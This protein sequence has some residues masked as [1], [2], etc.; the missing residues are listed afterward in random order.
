MASIQLTHLQDL[1]DKYQR[2]GKKNDLE[3]L[4]EYT[5]K[6]IASLDKDDPTRPK[7]I[8]ALATWTGQRY[9]IDGNI[10]HIN[11]SID[12]IREVL[13]SAVLDDIYRAE[14]QG[15]LAL[16]LVD[17]FDI[18]KYPS[19][20]EDAISFTRGTLQVVPEDDPDRDSWLGNLGKQL[21][22][23]YHCTSDVSVLEESI[24]FSR[25]SVDAASHNPPNKAL[26]LSNLGNRL[27]ERFWAYGEIKDL[28]EAIV[29][30]QQS[31][32][33]TPQD[34]GQRCMRL[35]NL[36]GKLSERFSRL[37]AQEDLDQA[38]DL[39]REA[40]EGTKEKDPWRPAWHHNLGLELSKKYRL[41]GAKKYL[42]EAIACLREAVKTTS[43]ENSSV[44][45][46]MNLLS[47]LLGRRFLRF[48]SMADTEEAVKFARRAVENTER[49]DWVY[50]VY[51]TTL[52]NR[53][54]DR[55]TCTHSLE[56]LNEA[57]LVTKQAVD[58]T[59]EG[60]TDLPT[61]WHNLSTQ[62]SARYSM[63]KDNH[64]H[65]DIEEAVAY[66]QRAV[67][68]CPDDHPDRPQWLSN[69][70]F[71]RSVS[72]ERYMGDEQE[73]ARVIVEKGLEEAI[74][75]TRMAV[76]ATSP[77]SPERAMMMIHLGDRLSRRS[78]WNVDP[79]D[80]DEA[81]QYWALAMEFETAPIK[82]RLMAADRRLSA[83]DLLNDLERAYQIAE[84]T[85]ALMPQLAPNSLSST[86]KQQVL[87]QVV[88][89]ASRA[90][91]IALMAGKG[92]AC[93]IKMLETG[94]GI[95]ASSLQDLRWNLSLVDLEHQHPELAELYHR[96]RAL[97]D[98]PAPDNELVPFL[99]KNEFQNTDERFEAAEQMETLLDKIRMN[100]GFE[101]FLA[102]PSEQQLLEAAVEG[103]VV[104]LNV[105]SYRC[106]ALVIDG[107]GTREV[108][109][110]KLSQEAISE[111]EKGP[112]SFEK[113]ETLEWIWD[114]IAE[115]VLEDLGILTTKPTEAWPRI[116]WIPTGP[117][118]RFPIHAAG[119]HRDSGSRT[120]LDRAISSYAISVK[121]VISGRQSRERNVATQMLSQSALLVSME[122]TLGY[123]RLANAK[124]EIKEVQSVCESMPLK[125]VQLA[126]PRQDEVLSKLPG[127][128]IFH[129][130]GHAKAEKDN[131]MSGIIL[132][133]DWR[134]KPLTVESIFE[135]NLSAKMPFL[136]YLSACGTTQNQH[137]KSIDE[138]IHLTSAFWL[139]GFRHV[140]G[141]LWEV[142][143]ELCVRMAGLTYEFLKANGMS[144]ENVGRALHWAMRQLRDEAVGNKERDTRRPGPDAG[145][146][147]NGHHAS[148]SGDSQP[149]GHD[150][151]NGKSR[152]GEFRDKRKAKFVGAEESSTE[153]VSPPA[154]WA[155]YVHYG[156]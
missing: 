146:L 32:E 140:I 69:L 135:T 40:I 119:Y 109:L 129:F 26:W 144:D 41:T 58:A 114:A 150:E 65:Q 126:Q 112:E 115:P 77:E 100:P 5:E 73:G 38:I 130:A 89:L 148:G 27:H 63:D 11:D 116:W 48:G 101:R 133:K 149:A 85:V 61:L 57:I 67:R 25:Q 93:A 102:S 51:L 34:H 15:N 74:N 147:D 113:Y 28:E 110:P 37:G 59:P 83:V 132:L 42:D 92:A 43:E 152:E 82:I 127:C 145:A 80:L 24:S 78:T 151:E 2:T 21:S 44:N 153:K 154:H 138:N 143:D 35:A 88:G 76:E 53:L 23:K 124:K 7:Q 99:G 46:W 123:Q 75:D 97:L 72:I 125:C 91:A 118:A 60:N 56:D 47:I 104:I 12:V 17:R 131:P 96:L 137:D 117:L 108:N 81:S 94:R 106:D 62:L 36:A 1:I 64:S 128:G 103:P 9:H 49:Q 6:V 45:Q 142:Q 19:D 66:A 30:L 121:S 155:P 33:L 16:H 54:R 98:K 105:S 139:A 111:R 20:I 71:Q 79:K 18:T 95:L 136:A 13:Q 107:H 156:S 134:E 14:T 29:S 52:G 68:E 120:V 31:L 84:A 87:E 22:R 8:V 4:I 10:T 122:E 3:E 70:G 141:T 55:H 39:T 50:R 86:D 90:A